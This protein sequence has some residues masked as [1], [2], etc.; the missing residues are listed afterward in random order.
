MAQFTQLGEFGY[1]VAAEGGT[2]EASATFAFAPKIAEFVDEAFERCG[3]DPARLTMRHVIS[4]RMSFNLEMQEWSSKGLNLWAVDAQVIDLTAG[5]AT[6]DSLAEATIMIFDA[7]IRRGN[8][9]M[10]CRPMSRSEYASI[11]NKTQ[12]GIPSQFYFAQLPT[13]TVT[14]WPVPINSSD[15]FIY[16]RVRRLM[17]VNRLS[18]TLDATNRWF[19]PAA[20]GLA[21][22]LALKFAPSRFPLLK[23]LAD[24]AFAIAHRD[25]RERGDTQFSL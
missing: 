9:D 8:A 3:V 19:E 16:Q 15:Q 12:P 14:L 2:E 7:V 21:K 10:I 11:A 18:D 13:P 5:A 17:D 20:A 6:Y 24:E 23:S 22:R 25:E 1:G 4:A